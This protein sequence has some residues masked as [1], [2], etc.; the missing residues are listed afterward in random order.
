MFQGENWNKAFCIAGDWVEAK[1]LE[2]IILQTSSDPTLCFWPE[3]G[4]WQLLWKASKAPG[5]LSKQLHTSYRHALS[6]K[7]RWHLTALAI[8]FLDS[9]LSRQAADSV[10]WFGSGRFARWRWQP[11]IST[12][13]R[14]FDQSARFAP[15][16]G[17]WPPNVQL[18]TLL[19]IT[20]AHSGTHDLKHNMVRMCNQQ[21]RAM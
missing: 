6:S 4:G 17:S 18:T 13:Q 9:W 20:R 10:F 16:P 8:Q 7:I 21:R 11:V 1:N 15:A 2:R 3:K 14:G 5:T 19:W 12:R